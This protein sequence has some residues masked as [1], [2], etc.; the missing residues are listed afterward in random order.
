MVN[1]NFKDPYL[2]SCDWGTTS[3]RLRLTERNT[4]KVLYAVTTANGIKTACFNQ[5][6]ETFQTYLASKI[7]KIEASLSKDLASVPMVISGMISS[8][9]GWKELPYGVLPFSLDNPQLPTELIPATEAFPHSILLI[10][11]I[12]TS[13]DVMRGEETQL[14][15][16]AASHNLKDGLC[17]IPGTHS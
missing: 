8:N 14:L 5:S 16:L 3:F 12:C 9:I 15:G 13:N 10:S 7:A 1:T 2:L 11:G 17:I 6:K 4:G